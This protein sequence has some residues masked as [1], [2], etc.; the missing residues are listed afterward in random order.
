ML[1]QILSAMLAVA[2]VSQG[3]AHADEPPRTGD[4]MTVPNHAAL[5]EHI[6]ALTVGEQVAVATAEGIVAGELVDKDGDDIVLDR[7]LVEGGDERITIPLNE[8][9]GLRYQPPPGRHPISRK[10]VVIVVVIVGVLLLLAKALIPS[11]P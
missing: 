6:E 1:K 10:E 4:V 2:V 8:V 11:G 5:L 3:I 7:P 9:Q